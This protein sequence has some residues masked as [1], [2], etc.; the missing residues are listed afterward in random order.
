MSFFGKSQTRK[1]TMRKMKETSR[2]M[3]VMTMER[4]TEATRCG[5]AVCV[6]GEG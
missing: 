2:T 1:T 4:M 5:W 3:R 6:R